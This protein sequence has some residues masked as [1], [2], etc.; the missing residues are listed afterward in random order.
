MVCFYVDQGNFLSFCLFSETLCNFFKICLGQLG[1][2][3]RC[4]DAA[5][6]SVKLIF[7][8]EGISNQI[9]VKRNRKSKFKLFNIVNSEL[10]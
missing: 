9:L 5:L 7:C 10:F 8:P 3:E 4:I 1:I 2:G 6:G